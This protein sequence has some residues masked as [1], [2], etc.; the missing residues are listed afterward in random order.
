MLWRIE[1]TSAHL[2]GSV[3]FLDD[4]GLVL[5]GA[6]ARA[7]RKSERIV[8]ECEPVT[9]SYASAETPLSSRIPNQ[10]FKAAEQAW[11]ILDQK[12]E[13]LE[14][15]Q[16]WFAG[17]KIEM[18]QANLNGLKV[19]LGVESTLRL[20]ASQ[21]EKFCTNLED[22]EDCLRPFAQAP[23]EEHLRYL[24]Y[25]SE[26]HKPALVTNR[27][28]IKAWRLGHLDTIN[29]AYAFYLKL[30]PRAYGGM[31]EGR[32]RSWMPKILGFLG[33]G[34][35]SIIVVGALHCIGVSGIPSL[36]KNKGYRVSRTS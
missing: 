25:V 5:R 31:I 13:D 36:L 4:P 19:D 12:T 9:P 28:L 17:V 11:H 34:I 23:Q 16:T 15:W 8:F 3:H 2:L 14:Y 1:G 6:L 7:F 26:E 10:L 33:D 27:A 32:S 30:Y 29:E 21:T 24:Q 20:L 22:P 18:T 35:P